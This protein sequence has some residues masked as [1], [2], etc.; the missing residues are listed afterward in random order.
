MHS[1]GQQNVSPM[2]SVSSRHSTEL[3]STHRRK[4]SNHTHTPNRHQHRAF[5]SFEMCPVVSAKPLA[6]HSRPRIPRPNQVSHQ[7][8][9]EPPGSCMPLNQTRHC[10]LHQP[11]T[12]NPLQPITHTTQICAASPV[13]SGSEGLARPSRRYARLF[14]PMM[15]LKGARTTLEPRVLF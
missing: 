11:P 14:L 8:A 12:T 1:Q 7:T 3:A 5:Q 13:E 6:S 9:E 2:S 10:K 4:Y 15:G